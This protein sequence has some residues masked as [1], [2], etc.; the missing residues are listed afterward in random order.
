MPESDDHLLGQYVRDGS[1]AAFAALVGRYVN[2]VYSA[3]RRQVRSIELAEDVAQS[4]FCD[5]A[6]NAGNLRPGTTLTSWLYLV[7][8][9]TAI[10]AVRRETRRQAREQAAFE[11]STMNPT[12]DDWAHVEPLLDEAMETLGESDRS[13]ILLRFFENKSLR[14]VGRVLGTSEATAQKRVS[15]ALERLRQTLSKRSVAATAATL[16]T[17]LSLRAVQPAP[18]GLA[19]KFS[20]AVA[21]SGISA[22]P[23]AA[24]QAAGKIALP[25]AKKAAAI[26]AAAAVI[27]AGLY[28]VRAIRRQEAEIARLEELSASLRQEI[29]QLNRQRRAALAQ[30]D[31]AAAA[32]AA[33]V[34]DDPALDA[35]LRALA[36][37]VTKLKQR[38]DQNPRQQIPELHFLPDADWFKVAQKHS[39]LTTDD[40]YA[41][42]LAELRIAAKQ[43]FIGLMGTALTDYLKASQGILPTDV[44]QLAGYF[45][46]AA[47]A[48]LLQRYE[49]VATGPASKLKGQPAEG[50]LPDMPVVIREK[51][52]LLVDLENDRLGTL[53]LDLEAEFS[54]VVVD[55]VTPPENVAFGALMDEALKAF[56]AAHDGK[57][58]EP[59]EA[60]QLAPFFKNPEDSAKFLRIL[61]AYQEQ[62]SHAM[63]YALHQATEEA[64]EAFRAI[65]H[66]SETKYVAELATYFHNPEDGAKYLEFVRAQSAAK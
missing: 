24:W 4:V 55:Q 43:K 23:S 65:H 30:A 25:A 35:R 2:L 36:A 64:A 1:D 20:S 54:P 10:D 39:E 18:A 19:A 5:L 33:G 44:A 6:H 28:Q 48:A 51:A 58:P 7:T 14:E 8:R 34:S 57:E 41:A 26:L 46:P 9:R 11:L 15:R 32:R 12:S 22:G 42:A 47:E 16:A 29:L 62:E 53:V 37:N 50:E 59:A 52:S 21:L 17:E 31:E 60:A 13:A 56:S 40:D 49:M 61:Q 3:A 63:P 27:I 38:L 66:G 45:N